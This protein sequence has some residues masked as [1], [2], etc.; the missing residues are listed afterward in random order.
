MSKSRITYRFERTEPGKMVEY[1]ES[2]HGVIVRRYDQHQQAEQADQAQLDRVAKSD[3]DDMHRN[4]ESDEKD[5]NHTS[6]DE[7]LFADDFGDWPDE[8]SHYSSEFSAWQSPYDIETEQLE[9][10]IRGEEPHAEKGDEDPSLQQLDQQLE[11]QFGQYSEQGY[12]QSRRWPRFD[13]NEADPYAYDNRYGPEL[14]SDKSITT[15]VRDSK[16][17]WAK[18]FLSVS[19][20]MVTGVFFGLF[21]LSLFNGGGSLLDNTPNTL[22]PLIPVNQPTEI[23]VTEQLNTLPGVVLDHEGGTDVITI[24][25]PSKEFYVLQNGLFSSQEGAQAAMQQLA[26]QGYAGTSEQLDHFYVYAGIA[27]HR[28]DALVLSHQ[29]Q[30]QDFE[31]YIK[32]VTIPGASSIA[33]N[34]ANQDVDVEQIENYFIQ[35]HRIVDIISNLAVIQLQQ[36]SAMAID[37]NAM[38]ALMESHQAWVT[39]SSLINEGVP[40]AYKPTVQKANTALNTTVLLLEAYRKNP[41]F[42][43]LWQAQAALVDYVIQQKA[44][45]EGISIL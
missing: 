28:D 24:N 31:T 43:Y 41:S 13:E 11:Q 10:L 22:D 8:S 29:L 32:T 36:D 18:L 14:V 27:T 4:E 9:K 6:F 37:Q 26:D 16:R 7:D 2:K 30:Q 40:E 45:L 38:T 21:V 3:F 25:V 33:W 19:G 5:E 23:D 12:E 44:L 34:N 1:S 39:L 35:G 17:R 15:L 20:A 42:A